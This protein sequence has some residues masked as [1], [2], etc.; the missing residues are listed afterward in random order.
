MSATMEVRTDGDLAELM[1]NMAELSERIA[2]ADE[3]EVRKVLDGARLLRE[4]VKIHKAATSVAIEANRLFARAIRRLAQLGGELPNSAAVSTGR[5]LAR[6]SDE[7]F[8]YFLGK[9]DQNRTIHSVCKEWRAEQ[10]RIWRIQH[11]QMAESGEADHP[12]NAYSPERVWTQPTREDV[13]ESANRLIRDLADAGTPFCR[14]DVVA[15][16]AD[17]IGVNSDDATIRAGLVEIGNAAIR[18]ADHQERIPGSGQ[19][20]RRVLCW[21]DDDEDRPVNLPT[22]VTY[23]EESLGWVRVPWESAT[24]GQLRSMVAWRKAQAEAVTQRAQAF[25]R[26]LVTIGSGPDDRRV[27]DGL[28]AAVESGVLVQGIPEA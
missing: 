14:E 25:D 12:V 13:K 5:W 9:V 27:S 24:I 17:A 22:F 21:A 16:L 26:L 1:S 20:K 7:D 11:R 3:P 18:E 2:T 19:F 8:L 6:L 4:W 15:A 28:A 23:E 10:D